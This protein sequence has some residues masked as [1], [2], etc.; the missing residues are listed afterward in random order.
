ML[1]QSHTYL[2][3]H[4]HAASISLTARPH[5]L[6]G[7]YSGCSERTCR[8]RY[9]MSGTKSQRRAQQRKERRARSIRRSLSRKRV[10]TVHL[11]SPSSSSDV[12][13]GENSTDELKSSCTSSKLDIPKKE[14][15]LISR[16]QRGKSSLL[17]RHQGNMAIKEKVS[18]KI[19][20]QAQ[21]LTRQVFSKI[22]ENYTDIEPPPGR[23][24]ASKRNFV[25]QQSNR[26]SP[27]SAESSS[28]SSLP[29]SSSNTVT[30]LVLNDLKPLSGTPNDPLFEVKK[31]DSPRA[32]EQ[33]AELRKLEERERRQP[34]STSV[35]A[36][37]AHEEGSKYDIRPPKPSPIVRTPKKGM[38]CGPHGCSKP[39]QTKMFSSGDSAHVH[40]IP[41]I[42][43]CLSPL[44]Q[45]ASHLSFIHASHLS[46]NHASHLSSSHASHLSVMHWFIIPGL[47]SIF[48]SP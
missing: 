39:P 38:I 16:C 46:F 4:H 11:K 9:T 29:G 3:S 10:S 7:Y 40:T 24:E 23:P 20:L 30:Q 18:E 27:E 28:E 37:C 47:C 36:I 13:S 48:L 15:T 8:Q 17:R 41:L 34:T 25:R 2:F 31:R 12:S 22:E 1:P 14:I 33:L 44:I 45:H 43:S 21:L 19:K 32:D 42:Q 35:L 5:P 26:A 6:V